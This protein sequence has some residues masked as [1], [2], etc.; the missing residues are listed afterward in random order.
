MKVRKNLSTFPHVFEQN[1]WNTEAASLRLWAPQRW[2]SVYSG[3]LWVSTRVWGGAVVERSPFALV[4]NNQH[5]LPIQP[6]CAIQYRDI[7]LSATSLCYML[8]LEASATQ[9]KTD[10][11]LILGIRF[12]KPLYWWEKGGRDCGRLRRFGDSDTKYHVRI[13]NQQP[14]TKKSC[15]WLKL[16]LS[17]K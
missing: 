12:T 1:E 10:P 2:C 14:H 8:Y 4:I 16:Y 3:L 9:H 5:V 7:L 11:I 17:V 15:V 6:G 13:S